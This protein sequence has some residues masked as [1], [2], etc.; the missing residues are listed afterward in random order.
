MTTLTSGSCACKEPICD[1]VNMTVAQ[2]AAELTILPMQGK[3]NEFAAVIIVNAAPALKCRQ[4]SG[5]SEARA[6]KAPAA[7]PVDGQ[8]P[9]RQERLRHE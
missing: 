2:A 5:L 7:V 4:R 1:G 8:S 9:L 3:Y 6:S